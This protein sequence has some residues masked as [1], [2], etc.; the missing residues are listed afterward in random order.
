MEILERHHQ[1]SYVLEAEYSRDVQI[2]TSLRLSLKLRVSFDGL[3]PGTCGLAVSTCVA[4]S[5]SQHALACPGRDVKRDMERSFECGK[6]FVAVKGAE[7]SMWNL[8]KGLHQ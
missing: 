5:W 3:T 8:R 1:I 7:G 2:N 6:V 4:L